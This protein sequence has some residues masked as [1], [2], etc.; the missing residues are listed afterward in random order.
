[1][2]KFIPIL[3]IIFGCSTL[4]KDPV[5]EDLVSVHTALNQA[6]MSYLKGC[7]DARK[8]L[9]VSPSFNHCQ[10]KAKVHLKEINEIMNSPIS[11]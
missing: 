5:S 4:K 2:N 9:K 8:E 7:V 10:Q 6:Q 3:F 1:M 11:E